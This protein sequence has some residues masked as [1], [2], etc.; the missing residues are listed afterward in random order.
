MLG[1]T[2]TGWKKNNKGGLPQCDICQQVAPDYSHD[3]HLSKFFF[4]CFFSF[5]FL[6]GDQS[7]NQKAKRLRGKV[8]KI[9]YILSRCFGGWSHAGECFTEGLNRSPIRVWHCWRCCGRSWARALRYMIP[10]ALL[11]FFIDSRQI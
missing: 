7:K 3:L 1:N 11:I 8:S 9:N 5:S 2:R 10:S 6:F 4:A